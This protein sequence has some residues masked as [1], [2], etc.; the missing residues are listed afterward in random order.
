M[1]FSDI[2]ILRS[3]KTNTNNIVK[4]FYIPVLSESVLYKRAVGFFS[5]TALVEISK[6]L[7]GLIKNNGKIRFVVSPLLSEEDIEAIKRGYNER[8]IVERSLERGFTEPK[9]NSERERLNWLANLISSGIMEIKVAFTSPQSISGMYHEKIGVL[10]DL[11][12]N[13]IAFTGSMNETINAFY[14]NYESIVVFDSLK[15]EDEQRV[16]DIEH[17]F[18]SLWD[19]REDKICVVEFPKALK[20]KILSFKKEKINWDLDQIEFMPE[21][22]EESVVQKGIPHIP[23]GFDL[24]GYQKDAIAEWVD[25]DYCGIFDM[26]TGTGKTYTGLGAVERLYSDKKKLAAIIV[27]PYQHLVEQWV[28]DIEK[29]NIIPIIG[30]SSSTQKDWK[31]RLSNEIMDYKLNVIPF[32]CFVTTNATF[33]TEYVQTQLSKIK[34]NVL[35]LVDE[36]HN[37]GSPRLQQ[38]LKPTYQYRL[39]LSATIERHGDPEGTKILKD[40]FGKKCIQYDIGRAIKEDKLT[41]YYYY[42]HIVYLTATELEKYRELSKK[43][44]KYC[45]HDDNGQLVISETGK[46][47]LIERARVVAGA[48]N[49]VYLLKELMQEYKN[50]SHILVYC[51][52]ARNPEFSSDS[53]ELDD[54]EGE[55]QIV[56]VSKML[57]LE[58]GMKVTHFTSCETVQE[59]ELIKKQFANCDPY[60]A[61]VAIKCLDEGVDIPSIK[62]AFILASSANPK[63]Y[64]QRRGRVLR[65]AEGK[66]Y[67]TIHDFVTL[68]SDINFVS[69]ESENS[70]YDLSLIKKEIIRMKEFGEISENPASADK[71]IKILMETYGLDN[72]NKEDYFDEYSEAD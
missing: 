66:K 27:C 38:T 1:A 58:L 55:R 14:N 16:N 60:Q 8:E 7:S 28:K 63:E 32:F 19:G 39:A 9:N 22:I 51:G 67:A 25:N 5:S 23:S 30:Y 70:K 57:G 13:R 31:K 62:T 3:Y 45:H 29:F 43:V 65:K 2:S 49:K 68:P 48:A 35:L 53:L 56:S 54:V 46:K 33:S 17:S 52:A 64:I 20:E 72:I 71:L 59:R 36:A 12:G 61:V 40:F 4:D 18:D 21:T 41:K 47:L 26:A 11:H 50:D 44:V 42:P 24:R 10:Y 34:N 37:F 6:G 15:Q 69:Y